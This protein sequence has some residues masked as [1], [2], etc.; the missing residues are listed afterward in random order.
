MILLAIPVNV[1]NIIKYILVAIISVTIIPD[2]LNFA[3][4]LDIQRRRGNNR[5]IR[6]QDN[7]RLRIFGVSQIGSVTFFTFILIQMSLI[8]LEYSISD[9]IAHSSKQQN[10][11]TYT[12]NP[13]PW[14]YA[15]SSLT[16]AAGLCVETEHTRV[17][18]YRPPVLHLEDPSSLIQ[19]PFDRH[20]NGSL[21]SCLGDRLGETIPTTE[22]D[23]VTM[24]VHSGEKCDYPGVISNRTIEGVKLCFFVGN[25]SI[26][27]ASFD[28]TE[29]DRPSDVH[30]YFYL[31]EIAFPST[32]WT[33]N[34]IEKR[35]Y[36]TESQSLVRIGWTSLFIPILL[37]SYILCKCFC[38]C[39]LKNTLGSNMTSVLTILGSILDEKYHKKFPCKEDC[40]ELIFV[41]IVNVDDE[42][43]HVI[44]S[45]TNSSGVILCKDLSDKLRCTSCSESTPPV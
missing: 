23:Y 38:R 24:E 35:A 3:D 1:A 30:P 12:R 16:A 36:V 37:L 21:A 6:L 27:E 14:N 11:I 10:A 17:T 39:I 20:V 18:K 25:L 33:F 22:I 4:R 44:R 19:S 9:S 40:D 7:K 26:I 2:L 13:N 29:R 32:L 45:G 8:S 34:T 15:D 41:P 43:F 42:W 28:R 5:V 31:T